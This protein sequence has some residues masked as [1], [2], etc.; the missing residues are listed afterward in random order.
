M[1]TAR[2]IYIDICFKDH[3]D[4]R[5]P[6]PPLWVEPHCLRSRHPECLQL[7]STLGSGGQSLRTAGG[8]DFK[9]YVPPVDVVHRY[10]QHHAVVGVGQ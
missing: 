1:S 8:T 2:E 4:R 6:L 5:L 9:S 10:Q 3:G 7:V